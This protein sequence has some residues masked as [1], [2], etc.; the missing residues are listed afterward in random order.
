MFSN[1]P[2]EKNIYVYGIDLANIQ[3][4]NDDMKISIGMSMIVSVTFLFFKIKLITINR[5]NITDS[6]IKMNA[7][8]PNCL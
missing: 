7:T 8:R 5:E 6:K 4:I 1:S 3:R 2:I